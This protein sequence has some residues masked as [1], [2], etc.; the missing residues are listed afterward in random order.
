MAG[1]LAFTGGPAVDDGWTTPGVAFEFALAV[2]AA[3]E[4]ITRERMRWPTSAGRCTYVR[5][6]AAAIA[7]QVTPL[8]PPPLVSQRSQR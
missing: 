8:L 4:T 6:V 2:P 7:V 5:R 3:L 1:G